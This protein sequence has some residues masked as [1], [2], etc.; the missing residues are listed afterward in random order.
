MKENQ[1]ASGNEADE[2]D[3]EMKRYVQN[4]LSA[5]TTPKS[6]ADWQLG[7]SIRW[8]DLRSFP[9]Q[10]KTLLWGGLMKQA[11]G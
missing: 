5:G 3:L 11:K 6:S 4:S 1:R 8:Y 10:K 2:L 9:L 7:I